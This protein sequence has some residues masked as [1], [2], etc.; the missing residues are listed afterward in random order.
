VRIDEFSAGQSIIRL[1]SITILLC[2]ITE[3][4]RRTI[5]E[6]DVVLCATVI[7]ALP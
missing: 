1:G 3:E 4:T 2:G 6:F 7:G 5:P